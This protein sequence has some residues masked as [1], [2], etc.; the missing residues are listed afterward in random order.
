MCMIR[1]TA[2]PPSA[3]S[4]GIGKANTTDST[5]PYTTDPEV[6][7]LEKLRKAFSEITR[8][9]GS[10]DSLLDAIGLSDMPVAQRYGIVFGFLVFTGTVTTVLAL[11]TFGG[12]FQRIA[13]QAETGEATVLSASE[14]RKKRALLL[15]QLLE[16]RERM[17][18]RY[19]KPPTTSEPTPL[20]KLL[21][22]QAPDAPLDSSSVN[23][24]DKTSKG[25]TQKGEK[26]RYIPPHYVENY[27]EAYRR[28]QDRPGGKFFS[29]DSKHFHLDSSLLNF[30]PTPNPRLLAPHT[31]SCTYYSPF[32]FLRPGAILSGR[33]EARFEA[34][35][36]AYAGCGPY[37]AHWYRCS[38]ARLYEA[39]SCHNHTADDKYEQLFR[40][41]PYDIVGQH[42]RLEA[43]D[44]ARHGT[45]VFAVTCGDP[46]YEQHKA[47]DAQEVWG[48]WDAGPFR[49]PEEMVQSF[50]FERPANA[51]G[52]AIVES[53]TDH[54]MGAILL[55]HDDPHNL[56]I[57]I[58][59]GLVPPFYVGKL[60]EM[61][62]YFLLM[63]RLFGLGYRRIQV[64]VDA[65]DVVAKKL[66]QRLG[67]N[68][69][70]VL[71][72]H[73]VVKEANR[74]SCIYGL[75]NSDWKKGARAHLFKKLYGAA[76]LR[77]ENANQKFEEEEE[78]KARNLLDKQS[79]NTKKNA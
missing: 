14:A 70:G 33:P 23:D 24:A 46:I 43:L 56:T 79:T 6:G 18:L 7:D 53:V 12:S 61:E 51:A 30:T 48:F 36:R 54:V 59:P 34:Y 72:K 49:S 75:L 1:A 29:L 32:W 74:D 67:F 69:D 63:D 50:V 16:G 58:E 26:A 3:T 11:L 27:T 21:L 42:V 57:S 62:A 2:P 8:N 35:A 77:F 55:T 76:A 39:L 60:G 66:C 41:R 5:M 64:A 45:A 40:D 15:E 4:F 25:K 52:F 20:T 31:N 10:V 47:Y 19:P 17:R 28:C 78:E 22:T 38:Y 71:L 73:M 9:F 37:V 65:Q 44:P 68:L 13:E